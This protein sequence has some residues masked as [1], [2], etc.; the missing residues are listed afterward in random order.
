LLFA[1]VGLGMGQKILTDTIFVEFHADTL[2]PLNHIAILDAE[3]HR[4]EDPRFVRYASKRKFLLI[5]VDQEVYTRLPLA[6]EILKGISH[7]SSAARVFTLSIDKFVIEKERGRLKTNLVLVADMPVYEIA[8]DSLVWRGVFFYDYPYAPRERREPLVQSTE[9]LLQEW[10]T[11]FK[12]DLLSLRSEG[13]RSKPMHSNLILNP[14]IKSMYLNTM[15]AGFYGYNFW[16]L[17]GEIYFS[18]PESDSRSHNIAG[19]VRYTNNPDYET[20]S[21]GRRAEHFFIR[22]DD[23]WIIDL[24]LNFLMGLCKWKNV[25]EVSPTL[26]QLFDFELSSVQSFVYNPLNKKG[27]VVRMGI[28]EN[29][30]Y[31]IGEIPKFH[32]GGFFGIGVKF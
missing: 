17:Q 23:R 18:R 4:N 30:S 29:L 32:I 3:D 2:L 24:D 10:H 9:N 16:G 14:E 8:G 22:K 15:V 19:I 12:L 27:L 5:P 26:Y 1:H 13:M 6:D 20:F 25:D 28:I 31:V 21:F 7:D 11:D